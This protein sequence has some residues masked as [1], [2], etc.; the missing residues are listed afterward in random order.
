MYTYIYIYIYKISYGEVPAERLLLRGIYR[1]ARTEALKER[2]YL[3]A[4]IE[5]PSGAPMYSS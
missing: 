1:E 5:V 2:L 3:E 4:P